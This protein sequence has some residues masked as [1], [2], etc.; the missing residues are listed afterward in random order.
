MEVAGGD[1]GIRGDAP[2][3]IGV[4]GQGPVKKLVTGDCLLLTENVEQ[5]PPAVLFS[6]VAQASRLCSLFQENVGWALPT[7]FLIPYLKMQRFV[8]LRKRSD[9]RIS[10]LVR[11]GSG[12]QGKKPETWNLTTDH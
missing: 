11:L 4:R 10:L 6:P 8:I 7:K 5:P 9:R 1:L 3:G 2:W 12:G